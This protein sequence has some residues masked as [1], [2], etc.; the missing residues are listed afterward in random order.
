MRQC[1]GTL[2]GGL[3]W[4]VMDYSAYGADVNVN[5]PAGSAT[6]VNGGAAGSVSGI[7]QVI[8]GAGNNT[9]EG[10]AGNDV[11]SGG[12]GNNT[13]IGHGGDDTYVFTGAAWGTNTIVENPGEG[14]DT[15]DLTGATL[16]LTYNFGAAALNIGDGTNSIAH[17]GGNIENFLGSTAVANNFV[18]GNG[19][20]VA[21]NLVGGSGNDTLDFNAYLTPRNVVLNALGASDGFTGAV[22]GIGGTFDNINA[23]IASGVAGDTLTGMNATAT[24]TVA[25]AY[26]SGGRIFITA[27]F[28][29][30]IGNAGMDIF[31]IAGALTNN[32]Q[33]GAGDDIFDLAD[34]AVLTGTID[35]GL[36]ADLLWYAAFTTAVN[37]DLSLGAATS[38]AGVL[39]IENVTG[40]SNNDT[41][42][43]SAVA[44]VLRGNG[45]NDTLSG[46]DGDDTLYGNAG[47]DTISGD[48]GNDALWGGT[49]NDLLTGGAGNDTYVFENAYGVDTVNEAA[50]GGTDTMTFAW[51]TT[52]VTVTLGSVTV[53]SGGNTATH[54]QTNV[55]NVIGSGGDDVFII[56]GAQ[57]INLFGDAGDDEFRFNDGA[58][59]T[60]TIDGGAG[61]DLLNLSAY[62][63]GQS[64]ALTG[65]GASD[66]FIGQVAPIVGEFRNI[67]VL[68]GSGAGGDTLTGMNATSQWQVNGASSNYTS[69]G[70]TLGFTGFETLQ[71]GAGNDTFTISGNQ[72]HTLFGGSGDDTFAFNNGARLFAD[73]DGQSGFDT[74]DFSNYLTARTI[75]LT[76]FGD[77][78]GFR[79]ADNTTRTPTAFTGT[80]NNI[81]YLIGSSAPINP[82]VLV[83]MDRDSTWEIDG[84]N[85]YSTNPILGFASFENGTGG[86]GRDTFTVTG[87][88]D[89]SLL[90]GAGDDAFIFN[91][92]A[93]ITGSVGGDGG[94][95]L[96]DFS[97][98]LTNV[99]I[100]LVT[101]FT[102]NV[103]G[104]NG[105]FENVYGG[106]GDDTITGNAKDN[107]ISGGGGTNTLNGG[108]GNDT[109]LNPGPGDTLISFERVWRPSPV[110]E[111]PVQPGLPVRII[112]VESGKSV[113][114][115][116]VGCS[117][118]VLRLPEGHQV[119]FGCGNGD[120]ASLTAVLWKNLPGR[121][122]AGESLIAGMNVQVLLNGLLIERTAT[123][124][125]V[126]FLIPSWLSGN[127]FSILYWNRNSNNGQGGWT[128]V[129]TIL[130][131]Y[132]YAVSHVKATGVYVMAAVGGRESLACASGNAPVTLNLPDGNRVQIPCGV[133]EKASLAPVVRWNLPQALPDARS[134]I[135][136]VSVYVYAGGANLAALPDQKSLTVS[137][138]VP[139]SITSGELVLLY[140]N[141]SGWSELPTTLTADRRAE[142]NHTGTG[143]Y[144]LAQKLDPISCSGATFERQVGDAK[145]NLTCPAGA[146]ATVVAEF[147]ETLPD[148]LRFG[149]GFVG[150]VTLT[151]SVSGQLSFDAP[152]SPGVRYQLLR[153]DP[154]LYNGAGGWVVVA[155]GDSAT[156]GMPGTY[157]LVIPSLE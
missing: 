95:D 138:V 3:G 110:V 62:T 104:G 29:T 63:T 128:A 157:I 13:L 18:F 85:L 145:L 140:W 91:N 120:Q 103:L 78:D 114:I 32:L 135:Y 90:G 5:L 148:Q 84:T 2:G 15:V 23:F 123:S 34:G 57:V 4:D 136:G 76:G 19:A 28:E 89:I 36:G 152:A 134:F 139:P 94:T 116:C 22:N 14:N 70:Q 6:A 150:G 74:I 51:V 131:E 38:T 72:T 86:S 137:L 67:N 124:M 1:A 16:A 132:G 153:F 17:N 151:G 69:G 83:G 111:E 118:V 60:G 68:T 7:E 100:N 50:A 109:A 155:E 30:L 21:G 122:A 133:G 113:S 10:T 93:S 156:V 80:F 61:S 112:K 65:L 71:G 58:T 119:D 12:P 129:P 77:V 108:P 115:A 24:W 20:V 27:Q 88:N 41:I 53:T 37:V 46:G 55:E 107:I 42:V 146:T 48:A 26:T 11:L 130:T 49:G 99:V 92:G 79:G 127:D 56:G 143:L 142:A 35:G 102:T 106:A 54:N 9:L 40:G 141:G 101:G 117:A 52:G 59:L 25:T 81:N 121:L 154:A 87:G 97:R 105:G 144:V 44:N 96:L 125:I 82:D 39:G 43:G 8:G 147:E 33:G 73:F 45:G 31:I 64:V 149:D 66:G 98:Y 75:T 47:N 126:S